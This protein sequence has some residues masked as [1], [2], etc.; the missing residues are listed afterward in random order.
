MKLFKIKAFVPFLLILTLVFGIFTPT[1]SVSASTSYADWTAAANSAGAGDYTLDGS[2]NLNIIT[3]KG[4]AWFAASVNGQLVDYSNS[5]APIPANDYLGKTVT[6]ETDIDLNYSDV[7]NN[8]WIPIGTSTT[9]FNGTFTGLSKLTTNKTITNLIINSED[10]ENAG[11]F[12]YIGSSAIIENIS[13]SYANITAKSNVGAIVGQNFGTVRNS[14]LTNG[15]VTAFD[16]DVGGIVGENR[17]LIQACSNSGTIT[18]L[19]AGGIAGSSDG[20]IISSSNHDGTVVGTVAGGIVGINVS[21]LVQ[22]SYNGYY[23]GSTAI[24]FLITGSKDA[25]GIA[26]QNTGDGI[27]ENSYSIFGVTAM[28]SGNAGGI[29][30]TNISTALV[31]N[32]YSVSTVACESGTAGALIG[33]NYD[34]D[35]VSH[36]YYSDD[37]VAGIGIGNGATSL[38]EDSQMRSADFAEKLNYEVRSNKKDSSQNSS[39]LTFWSGYEESYPWLS[40]ETS[41][42]TYP[43]TFNLNGG[44]INGSTENISVNSSSYGTIAYP[45]ESPIKSDLYFMGWYTSAEG[46]EAVSSHMLITDSATTVY[47]RYQ[48]IVQQELEFGYTIL[49]KSTLDPDFQISVKGAKTELTFDIDSEAI[50][51][52]SDTGIVSLTGAAGFTQITV[53]ATMATVDGVLYSADSASIFLQVSQPPSKLLTDQ[54]VSFDEDFDDL[55]AGDIALFWNNQQVNVSAS[56]SDIDELNLSIDEITAGLAVPGSINIEFYPEFIE[57]LEYGRYSLELRTN[58]GEVLSRVTLYN[59]DP[60][61]PA[62]AEDARIV[63]HPPASNTGDTSGTTPPTGDESNIIALSV[64]SILSAFALIGIIYSKKRIH[65]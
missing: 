46:G 62:V 3:N 38:I 59:P 18:G 55:T 58:T 29:V 17:G 45:S 6:L 14:Y 9:P 22:N 16:G 20:R 1:L 52:V 11:L 40:Q 27:I 19:N 50:A 34:P 61:A 44:S 26:G 7:G 10:L 24:P 37:S 51:T 32:C 43:V 23:D 5:S 65:K 35:S 36:L 47:A 60:N 49:S 25:G 12:G 48:K 8:S 30:G 63:D 54:T 42:T 21:G 31:S 41:T 64:I 53:V 28:G 56:A 57:T 33:R 4:L 2:G 39:T 13:I 15:S